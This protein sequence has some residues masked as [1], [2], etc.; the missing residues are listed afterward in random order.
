MSSLTQP[1]APTEDSTPAL[2]FPFLDL[3]AEYAAMKAE[4]LT[5][6]GSVLESQQF[7]M[8]PPVKE[9]EAEIASLVGC[10]FALGCAS[11]SDALL[12]ALMALGVD[13]GDEVVTSPFTFVATAGSIARLKAK[14][15]FV[16]IDPTTYNLDAKRLE[17]AVTSRTRAIMPV[18]LFGLPAEMETITAIAGTHHVPVIED[19]AQSIGAQCID[20]R[21]HDNNVG[22]IGEFGCF[23]FFPSKNLGGAG[24]GGMITTN[25]REYAERLAVLRDHGSREKYQYDLLGMNSRLDSLQ[26]AILLVKLKHLDRFTKARRKNAECYRR[27]FGQA[28]LERWITLPFEP[29]GRRHVYNQFVIRT[30]KRDQLRHHLRARG[31]PT[32]IYYPS[33]LHLQ[34]AFAYLGCGP[35]AFPH[36]EEASQ[37]VLALPVF[38]QM[39]G[40]QQHIV[41]EATADFFAGKT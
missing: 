39:T 5:E 33:P 1:P 25:H 27:L 22:N 40:E 41:V 9:L 17:S 37:H 8:G 21:H 12:L 2:R 36:A 31:I 28:G 29:E 30:L 24:D 26:A 3:K 16:D 10:R 38:P 35:G 14:P 34:P 19:A 20:A 13:S 4:I 18:H 6:V 23:S 15:V 11:G 32:E 7:I